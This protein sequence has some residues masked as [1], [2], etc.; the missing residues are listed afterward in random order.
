MELIVFPSR[1]GSITKITI[2][3]NIIKVLQFQF[4][5]IC[6]IM[7]KDYPDG[8]VSLLKVYNKINW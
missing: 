1:L 6:S 2:F 4:T 7:Y 3:K 5:Q 8:L